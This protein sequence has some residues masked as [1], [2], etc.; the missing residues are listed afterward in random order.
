MRQF[1][2][3]LA[4]EDDDLGIRDLLSDIPMD[5]EIETSFRRDPSIYSL[6]IKPGEV[7]HEHLTML[8]QD[9]EKKL[10]DNFH[11]AHCRKLGQLDGARVFLLEEG[12]QTCTDKYLMRQVEAGRKA[13]GIKPMVLDKSTGWSKTFKGKFVDI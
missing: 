8:A 13:G 7:A 4:K 10:S 12:A 11:Y 6:F 3:E 9:I 2:I 1:I 5:G